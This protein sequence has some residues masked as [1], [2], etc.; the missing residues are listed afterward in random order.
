MKKQLA[1][2]N[3][4]KLLKTALRATATDPSALTLILSNLIIIVWAV[5]DNWQAATIIWIYWYQSIIIGIFTAC[6]ALTLQNFSTKGVTVNDRPVLPTKGTKIKLAGFFTIHYGFFHLCYAL[7]L[8]S[9]LKEKAALNYIIPAVLLFFAN[10]LFSFIYN[11]KEDREREINIGT[12][13]FMPYCRIIPMHLLIIIGAVLP[14]RI[15]LILFLLL[16]TA[17]DILVHAIEHTSWKNK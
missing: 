12:L 13:L 9:I 4:N 3:K 17:A 11:E 15:L 2:I 10:H 6:K 5:I 14:G 16:K 1:A 8:T 7:L